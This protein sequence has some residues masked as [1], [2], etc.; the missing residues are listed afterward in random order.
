MNEIIEK[1]RI[2][3]KR[4]IALK[5]CKYRT[6]LIMNYVNLISVLKDTNQL[7]EEETRKILAS[8]RSNEYSLFIEKSSA[9]YRDE[10]LINNT[11]ILKI[12]LE[13][14]KIY[15]SDEWK[16]DISQM[17]NFEEEF[18]D[19]EEFFALL[20]CNVV[21]LYQEMKKNKIFYVKPNGTNYNSCYQQT[22]S[23][24]SYI[25]IIDDNALD[26]QMTLVHEM[27]HAYHHYL[28]RNHPKI[29][30]YDIT[31]ETTALFFEKIYFGYLEKKG[32]NV[33]K[34][35]YIYYNGLYPL[36]INSILTGS[37][38]KDGKIN[39]IDEY[40]VCSLANNHEELLE[41][42]YYNNLEMIGLPSFDLY[43]YSYLIGDIISD[44]FLKETEINFQEGIKKFCNYI[45][46]ASYYSLKELLEKYTIDLSYTQEKIQ[47]VIEKNK[48]YQK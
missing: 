7:T 36:L 31:G 11:Q 1:L 13:L 26:Q 44:K 47:K 3:K 40:L 16:L 37:L 38:I 22:L 8:I 48:S 21:N 5:P 2:L 18:P 32:L 30:Y 10:L 17:R 39:D 45:Q 28:L 25:I 24:D 14:K 15:A 41:Y 12:F 19:L 35:R 43:D 20:G 33:D 9:H 23:K 42:I 6:L 34:L 27:G 29:S 4:I 46:E